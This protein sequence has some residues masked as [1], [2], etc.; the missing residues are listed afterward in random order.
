M[1]KT[2]T[3]AMLAMKHVAGEEG[4]EKFDFVWTVRLKNVDKTSNLIDIIKRQHERLHDVPTEKI[5]SILEGKTGKQTRVALLFDGYDEYQP[6]SNKEIDKVLESGIGSCFVVLTSRPGYVGDEIRKKMDYEV[7]IE[8]LSVENIKK[9]S[10]LYLDDKKK[11]ADLLKQARKVGIYKAH[12]DLFG[13]VFSSRRKIDDTILRIPIMLLMTCFIFEKHESLPKTRTDILKNLYKL[14]ADRSSVKTSVQ[15]S[16]EMVDVYENNLLKLG[17]LA[18]D[19]L[20][21][22]E[23]TLKKV[24]QFFEPLSLQLFVWLGAV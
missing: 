3:V 6:G 4:M 15:P 11:S 18:W 16:D 19:A 14:L 8:G 13:K 17:S 21:E 22:D 9:C 24:R 2:A 5:K 23:L 12:D 7:I 10:K 1:G 20:K